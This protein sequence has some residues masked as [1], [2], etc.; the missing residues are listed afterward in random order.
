MRAL[1][2]M[3]KPFG[4]RAG[5]AGQWNAEGKQLVESGIDYNKDHTF[6]AYIIT[7]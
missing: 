1:D 2:N 4:F 3:K 6:T 5:H 7:R